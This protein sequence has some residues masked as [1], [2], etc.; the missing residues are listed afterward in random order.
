M[1]SLRRI[2][3]EHS[4]GCRA[5]AVMARGWSNIASIRCEDKQSVAQLLFAPN[6]SA[7]LCHRFQSP[8]SLPSLPLFPP[9]EV[10]LFL[11]TT[12]NNKPLT[13]H[14]KTEAWRA[15]AGAEEVA[16][17]GDDEEEEG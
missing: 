13:A 1:R 11:C 16:A 6:S 7:H 3:A 4:C 15:N 8:T 2:R 14:S 5:G 10:D 9:F 12:I 17:E